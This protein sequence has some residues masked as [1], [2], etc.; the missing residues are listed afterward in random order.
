MNE[1][2]IAIILGIVE[3]ITEFLP[4]SSTGHL[5]VA[6]HWLHFTGGK[7]NA[8]VIFI[9]LGAILAVVG[10]FWRRIWKLLRLVFQPRSAPAAGNALQPLQGR[11][12]LAAVM[13]AF[14]PAAV[15]GILA[16]EAIEES[17]FTPRN[18]AAM[19]VI[20]G[21]AIIIIEM[22]RPR[23]TTAT[24]EKIGWG[25][26]LVV[27]V[28]QC[29]ALI[30]GVSRSAATIMGG[31]LARLD[32]AAAAEFSFFLAMPTMFAATTY[33]LLK[34][35]AHLS[36]ADLVIFAVGLIVSFVVAWLVIAA[37]MAFIKRH[38]FVV[39]GWYRIVLGLGLAAALWLGWM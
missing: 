29:F 6:G 26:A 16:H 4:I 15:I 33:S 31:L 13:L 11:R 32:H 22:Q 36:R 35:W 8:F 17:L 7:A 28:A 12:F 1:I 10:Y 34:S 24:M 30:P 5:I 20:G 37:F 18:V 39:F 38:S 27:G 2:F 19:L 3:G 9:Q 25:Q 21:V 23:P 14:L